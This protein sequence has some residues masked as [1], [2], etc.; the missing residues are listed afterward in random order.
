M[1]LSLSQC[2][3]LISVN[4]LAL[5]VLNANLSLSFMQVG[6]SKFLFE[7]KTIQRMEL[8]VLSTLKWRMQAI[9]PF[10]FLDY[11]LCKIN[12]DQSPLRSS[13]M[14]SIQLISSTARGAYIFSS[15]TSL[16]KCIVFLN[17]AHLCSDN[18]SAWV[19]LMMVIWMVWVQ[20]RD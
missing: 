8:L 3:V 4:V 7:A 14:R 17:V 9:T 5:H 2:L 19:E 20:C 10:T 13:I 1:F 6:E 18:Y 11:F 15:L 16:H 12:D